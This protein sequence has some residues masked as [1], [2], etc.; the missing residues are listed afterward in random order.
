MALVRCALTL[1]A[2]PQAKPIAKPRSVKVFELLY[3]GSARI[4]LTMLGWVALGLPTD[5]RASTEPSWFRGT[6]MGYSHLSNDQHTM[7]G[8]NRGRSVMGTLG[9][10][11]PLSSRE[12]AVPP[13]AMLFESCNALA[14]RSFQDMLFSSANSQDSSQLMKRF[15]R[16][17][18]FPKAPS[19]T[20]ARGRTSQPR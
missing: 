5:M 20:P 15:R 19:A 16:N 3:L 10:S 18:A 1:R 17:P 4:L 8:S 11:C 2:R 6:S 14:S 7:H 13:F 12:L 9:F